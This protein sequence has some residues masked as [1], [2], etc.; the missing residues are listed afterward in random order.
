M[1]CH[2]LDPFTLRDSREIRCGSPIHVG[3]DLAGAD[4]LSSILSL[5]EVVY[6]HDKT[7]KSHLLRAQLLLDASHRL[8]QH[9][10]L[11][12]F[13]FVSILIVIAVQLHKLL[14]KVLLR[15]RLV[16]LTS[17]KFDDLT[18]RRLIGALT[19]FNDNAHDDVF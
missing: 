15:I 6:T 11:F 17:V 13:L 14:L 5:Y 19:D 4:G 3:Y 18:E 7:V 8:N 16:L 9:F 12:V 1:R 10:I 2:L